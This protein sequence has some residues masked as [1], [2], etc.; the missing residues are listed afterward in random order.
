MKILFVAP[1]VPSQLRPRSLALLQMLAADHEVRFLSLVHDEAEARLADD[2]PVLDRTLVPNPRQGAI[3]RS[4]HALATGRSLQHGYASPRALTVALEEIIADWRPDVVHL[5]VFRTVHLVE[6]CGRTPVIVDLD[7]F[8]SEYYEQLASHGPNIPWRTLG[9]VESRRMRAREDDLVRMGVP[10]MLSAPPEYGEQRPNTYLVRSPYDYPADVSPSGT[11]AQPASASDARK[12]PVVLFVGRL[13]Y[14]ANVSG[15]LWFVHECWD[16]IRQQ[17][18]DARLRIVGSE[19]PRVVRSLVGDGIE[20]YPDAPEIEP[21][22]AAASVAIA[23]IFRGTGVQMKLIQS[24]AAGVPTVTT[25]TVA[26]RAG[27]RDGVHVRVADDRQGWVD[28]TTSLLNR[29]PG[30][31]QLAAEG[32]EWAVAHHSWAAVR[33]QLDVA[34]AAVAG[35]RFTRR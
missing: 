2:L 14:E 7:E 16:G 23:P 26:D 9:L 6:A 3:G 21:H 13:S 15:L 8:R 4:L 11:A 1:W 27:V 5:N 19:P 22:Y 10:M 35:E 17:V 20:L 30:T 29:E 12:A 33:R 32:R 31:E 34:Y 24:L 28:A 18:P 25:V